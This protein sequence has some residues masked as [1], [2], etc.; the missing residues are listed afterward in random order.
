MWNPC[1]HSKYTWLKAKKHKIMVLLSLVFYVI[2]LFTLAV[3]Y[4]DRLGYQYT[5]LGAQTLETK[6]HFSNFLF[7]VVFQQKMR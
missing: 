7:S 4:S 3:T 2:I 1:V 6:K 5:G